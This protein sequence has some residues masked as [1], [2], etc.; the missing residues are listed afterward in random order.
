[1][2]IIIVKYDRLYVHAFLSFLY[3]LFTSIGLSDID[4]IY[5]MIATIVPCLW[6]DLISLEIRKTSLWSDYWILSAG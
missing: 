4:I 2:F 6:N 1:M 5:H 3:L